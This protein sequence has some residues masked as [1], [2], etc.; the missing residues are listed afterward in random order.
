MFLKL[1]NK[2]KQ[3]L[4]L[5]ICTSSCNNHKNRVNLTVSRDFHRISTANSNRNVVTLK[6]KKCIIIIF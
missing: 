5:H 2:N 6:K 3:T 1:E 4:L